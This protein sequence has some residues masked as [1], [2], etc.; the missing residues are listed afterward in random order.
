VVTGEDGQHVKVGD[1]VLVPWGLE[2]PV[3]ARILEIWGNP[4]SHVRVQLLSEADDERPILLLPPSLL[5]P[6]A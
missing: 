1:I 3:R 2:E 6:A 4:P 5:T